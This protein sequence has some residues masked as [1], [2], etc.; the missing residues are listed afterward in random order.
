MNQA[1]D[2]HLSDVGLLASC[3]THTFRGEPSSALIPFITPR[4][5]VHDIVLFGRPKG[6]LSPSR[7]CSAHVTPNLVGKGLIHIKGGHPL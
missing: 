2:A 6:S 4:P 7:F 1:L 5:H 3:L